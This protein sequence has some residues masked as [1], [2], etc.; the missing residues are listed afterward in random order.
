MKKFGFSIANVSFLEPF[1][2]RPVF[3]RRIT[4]EVIVEHQGLIPNAARSD[5]EHNSV[6]QAF[7]VGLGKL[8]QEVSAWGDKIQQEDKAREVLEEVRTRA[9]QINSALASLAR[10]QD[11]LLR[12]NVEVANLGETLELHGKTLKSIEASGYARTREL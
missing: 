7:L 2:K 9:T 8:T 3:I 10:N 11:E 12:L 4:G 1:F 6:R 5:F